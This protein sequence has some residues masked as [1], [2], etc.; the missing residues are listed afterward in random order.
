MSGA[1]PA[2]ANRGRARGAPQRH[3]ASLRPGRPRGAAGRPR[4]RGDLGDLLPPGGALPQLGQPDQPRA[5]GH[6]RG[7]RGD[8]CG[9]GAV[10]EIDLSVGAV[11]GLCAAIMAVLAEKEGWSPYLAIA[12]GVACGTAIGFFQGS[13]FTRF[14]IA[15]FVVTLAGPRVAGVPARGA[16]RDWNREHHRPEDHRADQHVLQRHGRLDHR[17]PRDRG[18]RGLRVAGT[19]A[20]RA[21]GPARAAHFDASDPHRAVAVAVLVAIWS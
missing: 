5:P 17:D 11:S 13:I 18:V 8:R 4:S 1:V 12:A 2:A 3:P 16:G 14:G 9:A 20:P 10:G 15:S 6:R 21:G 19:A 7:A